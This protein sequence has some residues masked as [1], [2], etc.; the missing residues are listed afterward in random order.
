MDVI[1][2]NEAKLQEKA[3]EEEKL[4]FIDFYASWCGPCQTMDPI[5]EELKD[6][7]KMDIRFM[8][9]DVDNN[10]QA[11]AAF[12]IK[13]VPTFLLAKGNQV[14][15]RHSGL[16]TKRELKANIHKYLH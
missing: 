14:L 3:T 8:K 2:K 5:M 6:E 12:Q 10:P 15:W 9:V 4:V 11:A 16:S 1:H 13:S 7:L